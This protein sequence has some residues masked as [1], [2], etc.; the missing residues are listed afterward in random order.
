MKHL[1]PL[2]L[3]ALVLPGCDSPSPA[4]M[5]AAP[6][7]VTVGGMEFRVFA[8]GNRAEVHRVSRQWKPAKAEVFARGA[9]AAELATGCRVVPNSIGGDEAIVTLKLDCEG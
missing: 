9:I 7:R 5:G 3:L 4:F 6:T 8:K 1:F 2:L